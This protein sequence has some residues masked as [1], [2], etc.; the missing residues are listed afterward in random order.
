ML[1][2]VALMALGCG[3]TGGTPREVTAGRRPPAPSA[4][5][6]AARADA[7]CSA[8]EQ[9]I[10]RLAGGDAVGVATPTAA[11]AVERRTVALLAAIPT[12]PA[13]RAPYDRLRA[14]LARRTR[15][16][17]RFLAV[18]R[19]SGRM[20]P[21]LVHEANAETVRANRLAEQLSLKDCPPF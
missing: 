4:G 8:A 6:F 18:L 2:L 16:R 10:A 21:A 11:V 12:P 15:L 7:V 20:S 13:L 1:A 3:A 5:D 14:A 19:A 9:R 17:Q